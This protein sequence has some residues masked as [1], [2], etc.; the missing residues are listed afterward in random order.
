MTDHCL[1]SNTP[2]FFVGVA[3]DK[4]DKKSSLINSGF[5]AGEGHAVIGSKYN[6]GLFIEPVFLKN[7]DQTGDSLINPGYT[8]IILSEFL[9]GFRGVRQKGGDWNLGRFVKYFF[10]P[11]M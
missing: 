10:H 1:V 9:A 7:F 6:Q 4:G 2:L 8:L 11:I 5:A 3:D